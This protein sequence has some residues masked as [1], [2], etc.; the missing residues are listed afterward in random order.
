MFKRCH[1]SFP[2]PEGRGGARVEVEVRCSPSLLSSFLLVFLSLS[3]LPMSRSN[4]C[5]GQGKWA[6]LTITQG[7]K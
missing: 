7:I 3:V 1:M 4:Q 5:K 6:G 2:V